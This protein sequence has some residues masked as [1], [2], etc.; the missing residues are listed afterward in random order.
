M[1]ATNSPVIL[2]CSAALTLKSGAFSFIIENNLYKCLTVGTIS[3]IVDTFSRV[4]KTKNVFINQMPD[5]FPSIQLI[6]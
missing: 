4:T 5:N 3:F 1:K 6:S 2:V